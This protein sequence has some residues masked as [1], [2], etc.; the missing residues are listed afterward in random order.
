MT[1]TERRQ[2]LDNVI[3]TLAELTKWAINAR[4]DESKL[5]LD[6]ETVSAMIRQCAFMGCDIAKATNH[7]KTMSE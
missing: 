1:Q 4:K 6:Y 3:I 2:A 7:F 5:N